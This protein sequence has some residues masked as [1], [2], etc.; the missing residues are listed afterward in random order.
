MHRFAF[1][2]SIAPSHIA[3]RF[4]RL[5][6]ICIERLR[7]RFRGWRRLR[8]LFSGRRA[9]LVFL[10][11]NFSAAQIFVRVDVMFVGRLL[12]ARAFLTRRFGYVL[13]I[14]R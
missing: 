11:E 14:L 10:V 1:Q 13:R 2:I 7:V 5:S 4:L 12:L 6:R 8:F 3:E 9:R